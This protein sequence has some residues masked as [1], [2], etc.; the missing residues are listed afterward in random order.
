MAGRFRRDEGGAMIAFG[1]I[2]MVLMLLIGGMAIDLMRTENTRVRL[3]N[4]LDRAIL[5][6]ADLDQTLP[7]QSVVEDYFDKAGLAEYLDSVTVNQGFNFREVSAT[8]NADVPTMFLKMMDIDSLPAPAAGTAEEVISDIE[9]TLVLDVSNSMNS[10]NRL[11]NLKIAARNFVDAV[12]GNEVAQGKISIS[13]VM[14]TGQVHVG[15][16]L[17]NY[18]NV[19]GTH[20]FGMCVNFPAA[21]FST[22]A[23][24]PADPLPRADFFDPWYTS[25]TPVMRYCPS[26]PSQAILPFQSNPTVLKNRIHALIADGNTSIDIGMKW[27][28]LLLDPSFRP[29][30]TQ[31]INAGHVSA[32]FAGRPF[33]YDRENTAKF[34][35]LM[36][37]GENTDE[38][39]IKSPY[40]SGLSN[41]YWNNAQS[42]VSVFHSSRSGSAKYW[43][44]RTSTWNTTPD[45]TSVQLT[46]PEVWNRFTVRWVAQRL[47]AE[48]LSQST[49]T[50]VNAFLGA[51]GPATK[52]ARTASI[53]SAAKAANITI[54][55]IAF[56]AP[57]VGQ[58][59]LLNCAS[60]PS[61]YFNVNGLD[62]ATAFRAIARQINQL[63]LTQ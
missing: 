29:V 17:I 53:C 52:D 55:A 57:P 47:F 9:I 41:I 10:N 16:P 1:I 45:G 21:S 37:D 24:N 30:L 44:P 4:T 31:L 61:H 25:Q 38:F 62:I 23:F 60:S 58:Q 3:Q 26:H 8:V 46:W 34:I 51:S 43:W 36:S 28:V 56:E 7:P 22:R 18:Y 39:F 11:Q 33:D 6:A 48:P 2:L 13:L 50:W 54:Y 63:R 27:G 32:A 19:T 35:I 40:N 49:N 42:R 12:L 5:A 14:Y 59:T 20:T 15:A